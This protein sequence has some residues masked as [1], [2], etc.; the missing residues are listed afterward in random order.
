MVLAALSMELVPYVETILINLKLLTKLDFIFARAALAR[1]Y[2][3][4]MPKFNKN[5]YIHIK[6]GRHPLLDPKKWSPSTC[7]WERTL[8]FSSSPV[9]TQAEKRFL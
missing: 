1:H 7:I 3:C 9:P 6:D 8:T 4:S 5:G 2:N